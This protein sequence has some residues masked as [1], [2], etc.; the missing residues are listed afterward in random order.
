[1][2]ALMKAFWWRTLMVS[3]KLPFCLKGDLSIR[4]SGKWW[5]FLRWKNFEVMRYKIL[6]IAN[7]RNVWYRALHVSCSLKNNCEDSLRKLRFDCLIT[8]GVLGAGQVA[9]LKNRSSCLWN[10]QPACLSI[11]QNNSITLLLC[12]GSAEKGLLVTKR[13]DRWSDFWQETKTCSF[14]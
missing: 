13:C 11:K 1:M 3:R 12:C 9:L 2:K 7:V 5:I 6:S 10:T 14:E 8:Q 4:N